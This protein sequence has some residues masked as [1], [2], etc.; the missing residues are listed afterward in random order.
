MYMRENKAV[1]SEPS[2]VNII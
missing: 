2:L 1:N